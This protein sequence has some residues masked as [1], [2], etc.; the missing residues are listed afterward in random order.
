MQSCTRACWSTR[1][2]ARGGGRAR[3]ALASAPCHVPP[4][5]GPARCIRGLR[6]QRNHGFLPSPLVLQSR[7][8]PAG[9]W[10]K[11]EGGSVTSAAGAVGMGTRMGTGAP[12]QHQHPASQSS[13]GLS[14][15][16]AADPSVPGN[17]AGGPCRGTVPGYQ[18]Q[19]PCRGT[20]P[21][22]H[23]QGP[24]QGTVASAF[25]QSQC[26]RHVSLFCTI[27]VPPKRNCPWTGTELSPS[28]GASSP[29]GQCLV[30]A[31][32]HTSPSASVLI[33]LASRTGGL[34]PLAPALGALAHAGC[35]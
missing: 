2:C 16:A 22:Y 20:V 13:C 30:G 27:T 21:R 18:A 32:T 25:P 34:S 33:P 12:Y 11:G 17:R 7:R 3:R 29:P 31:L 28:W 6:K 26:W 15:E 9:R 5:D 4:A 35:V 8:G 14:S 23:A 1:G 24:C 19:G 10:G